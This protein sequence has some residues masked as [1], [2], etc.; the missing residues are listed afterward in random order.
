MKDL[1][2]AQRGL[3]SLS[4]ATGQKN[5]P[6]A[7]RPSWRDDVPLAGEGVAQETVW[8]PLD[9]VLEVVGSGTWL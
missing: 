9:R 1:G 6:E 3:P 8:L 5:V 7:G 4:G 2:V